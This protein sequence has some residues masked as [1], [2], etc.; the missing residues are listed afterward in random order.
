MTISSASMSQILVRGTVLDEN[1]QTL[2]GVTV[3]IKGQNKGTISNNDGKFALSVDNT[4]K[5]LVFS[6]LGFEKREV[7]V[8]KDKPMTLVMKEIGQTL[9]DVVVIGYGTVKR[10]D[11]TGAVSKVNV[12]ELQAAPVANFMDAMAGRVAGVDVSS[13]EGQ[14]GM[15]P[16]I[17]IRGANSLTQ[18]NSPLFVIDGYPFESSGAELIA[19]S[20]IESIEVLKDA[21]ATAIYGS[22]GANGVVIITTKRAKIGSVQVVYDANFGSNTITKSMDV[23]STYDFVRLQYDINPGQANTLYGGIPL[24]NYKDIAGS[25]WQKK[26]F[27]KGET[28]NHFISISGGDDKTKFNISGSYSNLLGIVLNSSSQKYLGK[29]TVDHTFNP[30]LKI[31]ANLTYAET[32][33]D[34]VSPSDTYTGSSNFIFNSLAY[35]PILKN[36]LEFD[37]QVNDPVANAEGQSQTNPLTAVLS[38]S[39][40]AYRQNMLASTFLEYVI[41]PKLRF[42][43]S[44]GF[45]KLFN[46][47]ERFNDSRSKTANPGYRYYVGVS[48]GASQSE[49]TNWSNENTLT[50]TQQFAKDNTLVLVGGITEQAS[51]FKSHGFGAN[52]IPTESLGISGLDDGTMAN[53]SFT[54]SNWA[55]LSY[56]GRAIYNYKSR[57]ILTASIR[58][59]G[60]SKFPKANKW[61]YFPS[62]SVAWNLKSEKFMKKVDFVNLAKFRLSWGLTGN[63]RA[64]EFDYMNMLSAGTGNSYYYDGKLQS[65]VAISR[66]KNENLRWETTEQYNLGFDLSLLNNRLN[67]TTD[68]YQKDT[69]DL[70]LN[71][72]LPGSMGIPK[73]MKNIGQVRNQGLEI[74]ATTV[75]LKGKNYSWESNFNIS[76]NRNTVVELTNNQEAM[77]TLD[78]IAK[79]NEPISQIYGLLNDG[80][81][82][83]SDFDKTAS[84][85]YLLKDNVPLNGQTDKNNIRP[86]FRKFKD[87][88]KDGLINDMDRTVIGNPNAIHIGGFNNTFTYKWFDL[89]LFFQWSYGNQVYNQTRQYLLRG[90]TTNQNMLTEYNDRWTPANQ[91][92]KYAVA[93]PNNL[94]VNPEGGLSYAQSDFVEDA[95]YLRLKTISLGVSLQKKAL[96]KLKLTSLRFYCSGQNIY[97][98]SNYTGWDPEVSTKG[99]VLTKGWDFSAYPRAIILTGGVKIVL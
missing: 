12:N 80:L 2:S 67:L 18:S 58:A 35:K 45:N 42:R 11:L 8:E 54:S 88:N 39:V 28:Q 82:Q 51:K 89:S 61:G 48:G 84:G 96:S 29:I 19:P 33:T 52:F 90:N 63:N 44:L 86:G 72:D 57:Y 83:Y 36:G 10:K 30:K 62:G 76:F 27:K 65:G 53:M 4:S 26:I 32:V 46:Q 68:I 47:G 91:T 85:I 66:I 9:N 22:R 1:G 43:S 92:G 93:V 81:Y 60:S 23:M 75:N 16:T 13:N 7:K 87:L 69:R 14:P 97:T 40:N 24:D 25:N 98:W 6:Y 31:G 17:T 95:S 15:E 78:Y 37:D 50:F 73:A 49:S 5:I 21:S 34:G 71:A 38:E 59:D 99:G 77:I 56:L 94:I 41:I 3:Q 79:V 55:L 64:A 20:Q 74:T 70:L